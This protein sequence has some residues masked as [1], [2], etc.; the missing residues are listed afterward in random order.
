MSYYTV[1]GLE[2]EPFSTSPDPDFLYRSVN[3]DT[4]LKRLEIA[5]RLRRG[6]SIIL[7]DIGTGKT[8]LS[9]ALLKIFEDDTNFIFH[10]ILDPGYKS[11]FQFLLN[12]AKI[13]GIEP[14][15]RTTVDLKQCLQEYLFQKGIEEDKTIVLII[16]EGQKL[17]PDNL[18]VLRMLL[19]YETNDYKLLQLVI[20]AQ[21]EL[22]PRLTQMPNFIDRVAFK[23]TINGLDENETKQLIEYR[24]KQAGYNHQNPL[25]QDDAVKLIYQYTQGCPRRI[26]MLCHNALEEIIMQEHESIGSLTIENIAKGKLKL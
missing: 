11:E 13:F 24:L 17:T 8:T 6:L 1:L 3:H 10:I 14:K 2:K 16:D 12:L 26:T 23:Y 20:L 7:G 5:I 25:F 4:A 19:N 22:I 18:E 9:R 15:H 21:L